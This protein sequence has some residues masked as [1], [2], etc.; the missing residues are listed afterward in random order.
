MCKGA[1][2]KTS[3]GC[4]GFGSRKQS[5]RK[6]DAGCMNLRILFRQTTCIKPR[7]AAEL[8]NTHSRRR[9]FR[10]KQRSAYLRG[11]ITK[12]VLAAK[13]IKPRAALKKRLRRMRRRMRKG[14]PGHFAVACL[15][16]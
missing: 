1:V 3:A 16:S 9:P 11:V 4:P 2:L 12:Q 8:K 6:V 13:R 15:H 14:L 5:S 10:R 7:T